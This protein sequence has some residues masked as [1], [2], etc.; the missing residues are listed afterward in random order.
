MGVKTIPPP[1]PVIEDIKDPKTPVKPIEKFDGLF[2]VPF[3][4]PF[5]NKIF[6]PIKRRMQAIAFFAINVSI[7]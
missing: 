2:S 4:G 1:R 6:I 7:K 3:F 5:R